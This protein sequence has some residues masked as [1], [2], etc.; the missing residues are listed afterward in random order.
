MSSDF[1]QIYQERRSKMIGYLSQAKEIFATAGYQTATFDEVKNQLTNSKF[2]VLI[3]G[4]FKRGKS[5][6]INALLGEKILPSA[7]K[8]CT[9]IISEVKYGTE[10][11]A[12]IYFNDNVGELP[13]GLSE[14]ASGYINK[15][16][17]QGTIPPLTVSFDKL[18]DYVTI[19]DAT[20]DQQESVAESPF[21]LAEIFVPLDLCRNEV[22]IIDSPGLNEHKTRDAVANGYVGKADAIVFVLLSKSLAGQTEMK[23]I[24]EFEAMGNKS[25]FFICNQFDLLDEEEEQEEIRERAQDMLLPHTDLGMRG[26]HFVSSKQALNARTKLYDPATKKAMEDESGFSKMEKD[27]RDFLVFDR[28]RVKLSKPGEMLIEQLEKKLPAAV[29]GEKNLLEKGLEEVIEKRKILED[30]LKRIKEEAEDSIRSLDGCVSGIELFYRQELAK[31]I[32]QLPQR[33]NRWVQECET[34]SKFG[35]VWTSKDEIENITKELTEYAGR[36]AE[37]MLTEW[38]ENEL[39]PQIEDKV[40]DFRAKADASIKKFQKHMSN[41][42]YSFSGNEGSEDTPEIANF[43]NSNGLDADL[44]GDT[45]KLGIAGG[46]G[47]GIAVLLGSVVAWWILWPILLASGGLLAAFNRDSKMEKLKEKVGNELASAV[48][49]KAAECNASDAEIPFITELKAR[50]Q[51]I[52]IA[53]DKSIADVDE[54]AALAEEN[55]R[56]KGDEINQRKEM[57]DKLVK[58]ANDLV[59]SIRSLM[60]EINA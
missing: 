5:T 55:C 22:E 4:E 33:M 12:T 16:K 39:K 47:A 36:R 34:E 54:R 41:A 13:E 31:I 9:A 25:I 23:S 40:D 10:K 42:E 45:L 46:I 8:P 59:A 15:Y 57:L 32:G 58:K 2:K 48:A 29:T 26:L 52:S 27:L 50:V 28:G 30:E 6:F 24:K 35:I 3:I 11:S 43:L 7:A 1:A 19:T 51:Q 49:Q 44:L 53:F 18:K 14:E 60:Q 20:K 56:L 21:R 37:E 38:N 17:Q